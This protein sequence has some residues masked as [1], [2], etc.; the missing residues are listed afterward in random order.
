MA[1]G[2]PQEKYGAKSSMRS[3]YGQVISYRPTEKT[4]GPTRTEAKV[5]S[6]PS[7]A[8]PGM[9]IIDGLERKIAAI[10]SETEA[11]IEGLRAA[12]VEQMEQ[13]RSDVKN[14]TCDIHAQ[15]LSA[16][17]PVTPA[18]S[19][20]ISTNP[21]PV[22]SVYMLNFRIATNEANLKD[23]QVKIAGLEELCSKARV[24]AESAPASSV[25]GLAG[26]RGSGDI[27]GSARERESTNAPTSKSAKPALATPRGPTSEASTTNA[28]QA[29]V[30][31]RKAAPGRGA[32]SGQRIPANGAS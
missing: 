15:S 4:M 27:P 11:R 10:R 16:A 12:L 14:A 23:L 18:D 26:S 30:A 25:P 9:V 2:A 17:A 31:E 8:M 13:L 5:D 7:T 20:S 1:S 29:K 6:G 3:S 21:V 19:A 32:S 22:P 24:G 28:M